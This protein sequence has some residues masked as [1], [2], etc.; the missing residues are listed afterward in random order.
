MGKSWKGLE[1]LLNQGGEERVRVF[2][3]YKHTAPFVKDAHVPPCRR[4]LTLL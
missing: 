1:R 4:V 2:A 3:A